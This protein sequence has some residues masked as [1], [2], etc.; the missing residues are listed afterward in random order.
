MSAF[1]TLSIFQTYWTLNKHKLYFYMCS[2]LWS[3]SA[4]IYVMVEFDLEAFREIF[5]YS[6]R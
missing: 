2:L 6:M 3:A 5:T 1:A 4:I